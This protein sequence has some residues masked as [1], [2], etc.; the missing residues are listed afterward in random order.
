M[1]SKLF[2]L[3]VLALTALSC[4]ESKNEDLEQSDLVIKTG[5][6]CGWC[7]QN[8][9]LVI[10]GRK[11]KYVN[12]IECSTT[13][14]SVSKTSQMEAAELRSLTDKLD[15]AEFKKLDMNSCNVCVD[16]C[17]DWI[18]ISKGSE[19]HI[20]LF[21]RAEAKLQPI[22]EFVDELNALKDKYSGN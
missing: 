11:V 4:V 21:G 12:Y 19:K 22:K 17:D 5:T 1:I 18:S 10:S 15:F 13:N 9:T 6:V 16:G 2:Y 8:D 3:C 14:P 20:V 7:A